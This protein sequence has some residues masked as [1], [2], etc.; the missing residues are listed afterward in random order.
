[1]SY[2][3]RLRPC[4]GSTGKR[5]MHSRGGSGVDAGWG[6]LRRPCVEEGVFGLFVET[7]VIEKEQAPLSRWERVFPLC[8]FARADRA[9]C[10]SLYPLNQ[11]RRWLPQSLH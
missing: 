4:Y 1:M 5:V 2:C 8:G 10:E 6:R 7:F 3:S 11:G 9:A